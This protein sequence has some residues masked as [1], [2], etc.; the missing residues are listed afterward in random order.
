MGHQA[1]TRVTP[2]RSVVMQAR[3]IN[4]WSGPSRLKRISA[5]TIVLHGEANRVV[6]LENG[7]RLASFIRNAQL[8]PLSGVGH[9]IPWEA[10]DA[11][12][13]VLDSE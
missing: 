4:S 6:P 8:V 11:V 5:P 1:L 2:L 9:L 3:A 12:V 13:R 7:R 10:E